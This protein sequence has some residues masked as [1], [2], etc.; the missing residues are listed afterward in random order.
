[1]TEKEYYLWSK[2][3][4]NSCIHAGA[5]FFL[6][7]LVLLFFCFNKTK[8]IVQVMKCNLEMKTNNRHWGGRGGGLVEFSLTEMEPKICKKNC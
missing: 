8:H 5:A 6:Q 3:F 2:T 4:N 7:K 1:M